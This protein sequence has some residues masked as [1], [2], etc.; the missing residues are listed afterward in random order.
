MAKRKVASTKNVV[1][2]GN[3]VDETLIDIVEVR[4][5]ATDFFTK[6]KN[7]ILATIGGLILLIGGYWAYNNL[8]KAPKQQE[9]VA[10]MYQAQIQFE[11]D[12]FDLALNNPGGGYSGFL[13]IINKYGGTDAGNLANYYAGLCYLQ[14]GK[15]NEAVKYLEAYKASGDV[16]T[17]TKY[18]AL[19][20]AYAELN[21][22]DQAESNYKKA[23]QGDDDLLT[24]MNLK[25]LGQF[26][27]SRNNPKAALAVYQE[28]KDKYPVSSEG[29]D[30]DKYLAKLGA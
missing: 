19:G 1:K 5:N 12:S 29:R 13:G 6:N 7:I 30:I 4:D 3:A 24:P 21:K 8:Y 26:Y 11:K 22:M 25:K 28:I 17:Y 16:L 10:Q 20:D 18:S 9:A 15:F 23:T 2:Q 14:T 27:E